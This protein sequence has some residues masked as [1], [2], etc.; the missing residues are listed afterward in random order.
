MQALAPLTERFARD[1]KGTIECYDRIVFFGTYRAI[2]WPGAMEGCLRAENVRLLDY[3]K[4]FANS[5]RLKVATHV[6]EEARRA[7]VEIR[8]VNW[9]E[10]KEAVVEEILQRRGRHEGVICVLGAMERCRT[11][12]VG[13]NRATGFLE[14]QWSGGK[15]QHYYIYFIERELGLCYLR[16]PTWAPFRL[17]FYCNG[18]DWLERRM[19]A[20]GLRFKKADNCFTH[21]SDFGTAQRLAGELDPRRLHR[22]LDKA[23]ARW[24]AVHRQFGPTL[25]WSIYQAEWATDI[26]FKNNKV[27][28]DL[29]AE[30]TRTAA[31][32]V[33]CADIYRFLGKRPTSRSKAE[34]SSRLQTLVQGTRLKHTLGAT[35]LK[36]YDKA[37]VVLR[38]ECTTSDVKSFTH[39]RKVEPR[40]SPGA[41]ARKSVDKAGSAACGPRAKAPDRQQAPMRKTLYSLPA[42]S[43][44]MRAVNHRYLTH[45]S[46]WQD[47]TK[48]RHD[49]RRLT[50]SVRDEK[51][52][53]HR[54]VNFF[55]EDDQ[56]FMAALLRGEHHL[57][58]LRNRTLGGRLPGWSPAKIGR[59]L[60]RF[61]AHGLL[62]RVAGTHKYYLTKHGSASLVVGRQLVERLVLPALA[63]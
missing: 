32:E 41:T 6:R 57:R 56:Q 1:I 28:P 39:Y 2:G 50:A 33:G 59:T 5:L 34:V 23:A 36:M 31:C 46:Q 29:Y 22:I 38:I 35:S 25:H 26:V 62:K 37:G 58:G 55:R 42:L 7:G 9:S 10:R 3:T 12:K 15:C 17:Q 40:R 44:A 54:G 63:A 61:R 51:E 47:R 4:G 8:Q 18:H 21:I 11:Y 19:K 20:K 43:E 30:I 60:R 53:S 16:I 24:V 52:R 45:I 13:K 14:L 49:L 48:E 27:L